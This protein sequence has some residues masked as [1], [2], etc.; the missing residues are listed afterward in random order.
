MKEQ[1]DRNLKIY[2]LN[3]ILYSVMLNL[4][5]PFA[6]KFLERLG[7]TEFH[8]SLLNALP[9][10][11]AV[12]ATLPGILLVLRFPQ[13]KKITAL[14]FLLSRVFLLFFAFI[15]WIPVD[16]QPLAFVILFS[17]R[18]FPDSVSQSA[19]QSFSGDLFTPEARST[20]ITLR[21]RFS[22]PAILLVTFAA[23][24]ILSL[25]AAVEGSIMYTY[26]AFFI[27]AFLLGMAETGTFMLFKEPPVQ[28]KPRPQIKETFK[29]VVKDKRFRSFA[30]TSLF[31]YFT[32]QMGWPLFNIYQIITMKADEW[33][34][35]LISIF[36]SIGMFLGYKFW[37]TIIQQKGNRYVMWLTTVGMSLNPVLMILSQNLYIYTLFN[38][39]LG[40]FTAGTTT[41]LLSYLLEVTPD[42]NRVVYIGVYNTLVNISLAVSP[43]AAHWV[44]KSTNIYIAILVVAV[45][46][47]ISSMVLYASNRKARALELNV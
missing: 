21:N 24:R 3:G 43:F 26:Q 6:P 15:P 30:K 17:L 11:V 23:G 38:I 33:W 45:L 8:I 36:S 7:G 47:F 2:I 28:D 4:Y 44:L 9:G 10:L 35:S 14:F 34:L 31:F 5:S 29:S 18:N 12:F 27:V 19:L 41:V 40:F 13:K 16:L 22:I 37:N 42:E 1:W 25:L 32:W 46:R 39:V 20:A